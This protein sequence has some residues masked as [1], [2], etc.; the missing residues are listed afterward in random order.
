MHW[1]RTIQSRTASFRTTWS[2]EKEEKYVQGVG[3]L[4]NN[5]RCLGVGGKII[6]KL[7]LAAEGTRGWTE[8]TVSGSRKGHEADSCENGNGHFFPHKM[9]K[10]SRLAEELYAL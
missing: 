7:M 9:R 2:Y 5:L 4:R 8:F 1:I 3:E 10:I 6:L